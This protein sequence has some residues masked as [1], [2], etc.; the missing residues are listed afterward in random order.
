M[1]IWFIIFLSNSVISLLVIKPHGIRPTSSLNSCVF[2]WRRCPWHWLMGECFGTPNITFPTPAFVHPHLKAPPPRPS[3]WD[4]WRWGSGRKRVDEYLVCWFDLG[5][6]LVT[7]LKRDNLKDYQ[8]L[9]QSVLQNKSLVRTPKYKE[10][11]VFR[12]LERISITILLRICDLTSYR[13]L[14]FALF[15][16]TVM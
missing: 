9:F 11:C 2:V 15:P 12:F 7:P 8:F 16:R 6:G 1:F 4:G 5:P 13:R 10:V 14:A 3:R